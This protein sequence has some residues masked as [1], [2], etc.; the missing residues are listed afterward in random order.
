MLHHQLHLSLHACALCRS[1]FMS[2]V[3][4]FT[5]A[6]YLVLGSR[7]NNGSE[8]FVSTASVL[9][10]LCDQA[11]GEALSIFLSFIPCVYGCSWYGPSCSFLC[12]IRVQT[13]P[14]CFL[15]V[16]PRIKF[17]LSLPLSM[18]LPMFQWL[19]CFLPLLYQFNTSVK[20]RV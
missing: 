9:E 8:L 13:G 16:L 20:R 3:K 12:V 18:I 11:Q 2:C 17:F 4:P 6:H 10:V 7:C 1:F 19:Q 5:A 14:G 15:V